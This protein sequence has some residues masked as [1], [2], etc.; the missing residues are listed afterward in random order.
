MMAFDDALEAV[1]AMARPRGAEHVDLAQAEGRV[2]ARPLVARSASPA[3]DV[4]AMDGY[5]AL[6]ADLQVPGAALTLA[7]EARPGSV[8]SDALAPGL[9]L[10]VFTGAPAPLGASRIV[11]QEEVRREGDVVIFP[12]ACPQRSHVRKAG[13][14]F[15]AGDVLLEAGAVLDAPRMVALA[16]ADLAEVEV[17]RRPRI[18]L[19]ATGDEIRA[20]GSGGGGIPDSLSFGVAALVRQWG[21]EVVGRARH[22]DDLGDLERAAAEALADADIVVVSG[23]AS[24]G[25][26][27]LARAMFAAHG[28]ELVVDKVAIKPGKPVWFGRCQGK[29]IAGLPGNPTSAMVTARLLLAP[30]VA[31]VAGRGGAAA[32]RWDWERL[33]ADLP[34]CG[35]RETYVRV[36]RAE[37]GVAPLANQDSASQAMLGRSD[38][39]V[40]RRPGEPVLRAG[41]FVR[42]LAF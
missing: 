13:S 30:L 36:A 41:E 20:P 35:E 10:R 5:A 21:G 19:I 26:H 11:L 37:G 29:L 3:T 15:A 9:C 2:L 25:D 14:D 16:A 38:G 39:L 22:V 1:L 6:D 18:R 7:G 28:L 42:M 4:S 34:S 12:A 31:V 32:S 8:P 27:D 33:A 24:V 23:G 40:R 17:Y